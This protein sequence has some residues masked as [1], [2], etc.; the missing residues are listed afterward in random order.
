MR[1]RYTEALLLGEVGKPEGNSS[2]TLGN[3]LNRLSEIGCVRIRSGKGK[4]VLVQRGEHFADL[5]PISSRIA[6]SAVHL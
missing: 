4:E 1:K 5:L 3:A 6:K 2:V